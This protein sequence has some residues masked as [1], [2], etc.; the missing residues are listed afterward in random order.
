MHCRYLGKI[1]SMWLRRA[2]VPEDGNLGTKFT[3]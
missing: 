3:G 1:L 2:L